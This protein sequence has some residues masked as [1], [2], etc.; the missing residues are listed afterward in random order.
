MPP[1]PYYRH[2]LTICG[3]PR[4]SG[5]LLCLGKW[6]FHS[7]TKWCFRRRVT[8]VSA[9]LVGVLVRP[10]QL[11]KRRRFGRWVTRVVAWLVV[12]LEASLRQVLS[13]MKR[14]R[15]RRRMPRVVIRLA[16]AFEASFRR[17]LLRFFEC[18]RVLW[19]FYTEF[20]GLLSCFTKRKFSC[21]RLSFSSS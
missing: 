3:V 21:E 12:M 10:L 6:R 4:W 2:V 1:T 11:M 14:R 15:F 17:I 13:L 16:D 18:G 20:K 5:G 9:L 19:G 8:R 7:M